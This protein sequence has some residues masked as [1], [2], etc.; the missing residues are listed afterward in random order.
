MNRTACRPSARH[1]HQNQRRKQ[2]SVTNFNAGSIDSVCRHQLQP[3]RGQIGCPSGAVPV[4][5]PAEPFG[6]LGPPRPVGWH[7]QGLQTP[8][9]WPQLEAPGLPHPCSSQ[10]KTQT[11]W[12]HLSES[13]ITSKQQIDGRFPGTATGSCLT[14]SS[15]F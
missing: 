15:L 3:E 7:T 12:K 9:E 1:N 14:A 2:S 5:S 13:F 11:C 10:T 4:W 8:H 6:W